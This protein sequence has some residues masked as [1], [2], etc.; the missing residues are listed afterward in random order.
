MFVRTF[1]E[2]HLVFR[3]HQQLNSSTLFMSILCFVFSPFFLRT[4]CC[5]IVREWVCSVLFFN[6]F[7]S[8]F[9]FAFALRIE[10]HLVLHILSRR[11]PFHEC[12]YHVLWMRCTKHFQFKSIEILPKHTHRVYEWLKINIPKNWRSKADVAQ[13]ALNIFWIQTAKTGA[14]YGASKNTCSSWFWMICRLPKAKRPNRLKIDICLL[15]ATQKYVTKSRVCF[16]L[17][18]FAFCISHFHQTFHFPVTIAKQ[19]Y[20]MVHPLIPM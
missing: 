15:R 16:A 20:R 18:P 11:A 7:H 17:A 19:L 2:K 1:C 8:I 5:K 4:I 13:I 10:F 9:V 6:S 3:Y 12:H 14:N